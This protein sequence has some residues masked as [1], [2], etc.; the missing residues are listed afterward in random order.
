[1]NKRFFNLLEVMLVIGYDLLTDQL[2]KIFNQQVFG[3][4]YITLF[5]VCY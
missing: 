3:V 5:I 2:L 4:D 1:M